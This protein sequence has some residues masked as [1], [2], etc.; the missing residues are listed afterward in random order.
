MRGVLSQF[1]IFTGGGSR[2]SRRGS[3]GVVGGSQQGV[4]LSLQLIGG[5]CSF[6][7]ML[8]SSLFI[9]EFGSGRQKGI[10][11]CRGAF[12]SFR[13]DDVYVISQGLSWRFAAT[14]DAGRRL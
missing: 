8:L 13:V 1:L 9:L 10:L 4:G 11:S 3:L 7:D 12:F 14:P 5:Q 2:L 6:L